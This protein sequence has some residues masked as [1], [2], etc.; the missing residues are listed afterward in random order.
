MRATTFVRELRGKCLSLA[1]FSRAFP[2][3]PRYEHHD[4]RRRL[5]R[6]YL[7]FYRVTGDD[8]EILRIVHG[9]RDLETLIFPG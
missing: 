7:I 6:N 9:R 2:L 1:G 4:I 5:Y 8:V 3:L